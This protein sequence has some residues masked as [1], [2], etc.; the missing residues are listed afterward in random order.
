MT[1]LYSDFARRLGTTRA[2]AKRRAY[3]RALDLPLQV[4]APGE[5]VPLAVRWP[6]VAETRERL[7]RNGFELRTHEGQ[8]FLLPMSW[9]HDHREL[10]GLEWGEV[11]HRAIEAHHAEWLS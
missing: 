3:E 9:L 6:R 10:E 4:L 11:L 5:Q 1:D 8:R 2:E 7:E